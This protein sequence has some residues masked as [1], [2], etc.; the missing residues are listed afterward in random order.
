MQSY[1]SG[2]KL[3]SLLIKLLIG[4]L[5][6]SVGTSQ[7][8]AQATQSTEADFSISPISHDLS[9]LP[10]QSQELTLTLRSDLPQ[11]ATFSLSA[12]LFSSAGELSN[13]PEQSATTNW[14]NYSTAQ[15]SLEPGQG[16]QIGFMITLPTDA[17]PGV[18]HLGTIIS[19]EQDSQTDSSSSAVIAQIAQRINL[20]VLASNVARPSLSIAALG[21]PSLMLSGEANYSWS[22][23]NV[24]DLFTRPVIYTQIVSPAGEILSTEVHN[25]ELSLVG[26]GATE[27]EVLQAASE[28]F[29]QPGIYRFEVLVVDSVVD[30]APAISK[31]VGTL[32]I[33]LWLALPIL[34]GTAVIAI[35]AY[36]LYSKRKRK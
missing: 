31:Y 17:A 33:P 14:L 18:Y 9:L 35:G 16:T 34:I 7:V 11:T 20:N 22:V 21:G 26:P 1:A 32:Y 3:N 4:V 25:S 19:L 2:K 6:L 10:G 28:L 24:S 15:I 8:Q 30:G 5:V 27:G 23:Q 29:T 12:G 13:Q 36:Q